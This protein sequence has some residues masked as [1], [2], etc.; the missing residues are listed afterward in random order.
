MPINYPKNRTQDLVETLDG[1]PISDPYR[2]MEDLE[3]G[4]YGS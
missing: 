4:E 2:W 1:Q 3:S